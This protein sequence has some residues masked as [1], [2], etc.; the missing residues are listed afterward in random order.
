MIVHWLTDQTDDFFFRY[1]TLV[2]LWPYLFTSWL[3]LSK[4]CMLLIKTSDSWLQRNY[5]TGGLA[6]NQIDWTEEW[7]E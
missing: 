6:R 1:E 3:N 7:T 4:L 2:K 5:S